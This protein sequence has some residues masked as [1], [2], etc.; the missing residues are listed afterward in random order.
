MEPACLL[1]TTVRFTSIRSILCILKPA[2]ITLCAAY[3]PDISFVHISRHDCPAVW[4]WDMCQ[5]SHFSLFITQHVQYY[6]LILEEMVWKCVFFSTYSNNIMSR[7][8]LW[9]SVSLCPWLCVL[10]TT[11]A[12][13][14]FIMVEQLVLEIWSVEVLCFL[15]Q[16]VVFFNV[17]IMPGENLISDPCVEKVLFWIATLEGRMKS[18]H[19]E[20]REMR[21]LL[22]MS[23]MVHILSPG[24]LLQFCAQ[25]LTWKVPVKES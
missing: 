12:I 6:K 5:G 25:L 7:F 13:F 3:L 10:R 21:H 17:C 24:R 11:L 9:D 19:P 8:S 22:N 2:Y 23:G 16:A 1:S 20:R 15:V 14:I 4:R 18:W